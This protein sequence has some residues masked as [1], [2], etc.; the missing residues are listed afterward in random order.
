MFKPEVL[1]TD[2]RIGKSPIMFEV[3]WPYNMDI[4]TEEDWNKLISL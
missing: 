1:D 2:N 4:D 3:E